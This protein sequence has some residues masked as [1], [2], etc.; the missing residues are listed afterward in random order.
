MIWVPVSS[1][2]GFRWLYGASPS[3]AAKNN[4]SDFSIEHLVMSMCRVV[5]CVV[6]RGCLLWP[7]QSLGKILLAFDLLR[8]V[9]QGQAWLNARQLA[10]LFYFIIYYLFLLFYYF[11]SHYY[12]PTLSWNAYAFILFRGGRM[13]RKD[14]TISR[15]DSNLIYAIEG[16]LHNLE[17]KIFLFSQNSVSPC[18]TQGPKVISAL[19]T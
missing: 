1:Q 11:I 7:V 18:I 10:L 17:K 14:E 12:S 13:Q 15:K 9:P 8:F 4:Q 5:S 6:E 19:T 3:L 16:N 2:S